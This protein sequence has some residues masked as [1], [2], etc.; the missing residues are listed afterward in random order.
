MTLPIDFTKATGAGNDFV[1]VDDM[2]GDLRVDLPALARAVCD[3]HF[4]IGGDGLLVLE[5]SD[6][7]EFAMRY[8]NADGSW[9]GMCGNGGRCIARFA[10]AHKIAGRRQHFEALGHVYEAEVD[11]GAVRLHMKDPVEYRAD[12]GIAVGNGRARAFFVN[13]GAPHAVILVDDPAMV[14]VVRDGHAIRWSPDF[15]PEG[16]NVNFVWRDSAGNVLLRTYERGVEAETLACGTGSIATALVASEAFGL[17]SPVSVHVRSGETLRVH[18]AGKHGAWSN[19][20]LEGSAR[21][22]FSG[23]VLYNTD[24]PTL[25]AAL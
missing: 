21:L 9:G 15:A 23:R 10:F 13:T 11:A 6:R 16:T 12:I 1:I 24:P 18:F 17:P 22:V 7:A 3:R 19:V 4:G 5:K 14:D 25:E 2:R 8:Y 20:V